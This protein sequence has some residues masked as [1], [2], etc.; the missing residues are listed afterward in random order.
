M[1]QRSKS[2]ESALIRPISPISGGGYGVSME[3]NFLAALDRWGC[4]CGVRTTLLA[5][6]AG[7]MRCLIHLTKISPVRRLCSLSEVCFRGEKK[8]T[9]KKVVSFPLR[10]SFQRC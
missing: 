4:A 8:R 3:I 9:L 2:P 6:M 7:G 1:T 10:L 5:E